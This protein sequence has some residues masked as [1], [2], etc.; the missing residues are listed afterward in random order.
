MSARLIPNAPVALI[1]PRCKT[2]EDEDEE[3]DEEEAED[4]EDEEEEDED[5]LRCLLR[6]KR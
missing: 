5:L 3:E 6:I 2:S 4:D 1:L